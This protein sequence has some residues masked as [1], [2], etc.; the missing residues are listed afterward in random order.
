MHLRLVFV[1]RRFFIAYFPVNNSLVPAGADK[2]LTGTFAPI[3]KAALGGPFYII[4]TLSILPIH[5][6]LYR[7]MHF[8]PGSIFSLRLI[9]AMAIRSLW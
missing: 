9:A 8:F 1:P 4:P 3:K 2:F 7:K 6:S 5:G